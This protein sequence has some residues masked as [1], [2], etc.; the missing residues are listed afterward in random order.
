MRLVTAIQKFSPGD[1]S[2]EL[3]GPVFRIQFDLRVSPDQ[4]DR[5]GT[6]AARGEWPSLRYSNYLLNQR[7]GNRDR[8]YLSHLPKVLNI[9]ILRELSEIW[10]EEIFITASSRLRG[11]RRELNLMFLGTWYHIEKHREAML[12]SFIMLKTDANQDG[13]ISVDEWGEM[14][15]RIGAK[16]EEEMIQVY[17][18]F[19]PRRGVVEDGLGTSA[20]KETDYEWLSSDGYPLVGGKQDKIPDYRHAEPVPTV[21]CR[22]NVSDCFPRHVRE[23][24]FGAEGLLRRVASEQPKCGDCLLALLVGQQPAGIDALLPPRTLRTQLAEWLD[25][26]LSLATRPFATFNKRANLTL[27]FSVPFSFPIR[28]SRPVLLTDDP[29]IWAIRNIQRYQYVLGT[30]PSKFDVLT[31]LAASRLVLDQ[32]SDKFTKPAS[33]S[34]SSLPTGGNQL[35]K[36]AFLVTI[37]DRIF[38]PHLRSVHALFSHWLNHSWPAPGPWE[39]NY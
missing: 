17:K 28:F 23:G 15:K 32:L 30:S 36:S 26:R 4:V 20:P 1:F 14:M 2:S 7:F 38:L 21:F 31:T 35:G 8:R 24:R 6:E 10:R 16:E 29:R 25:P 34:S 39:I 33:P 18:P 13:E 11:Q 37:N 22:L 5:S 9:H 3:F 27:F 19:R 12:H